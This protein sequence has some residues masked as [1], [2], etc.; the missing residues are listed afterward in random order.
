MPLSTPPA[1]R[2]GN[3]SAC[4]PITTGQGFGLWDPE[5]R[6]SYHD[7]H[8]APARRAPV[9]GHPLVDDVGHGAHR[10]CRRKGEQQAGVRAQGWGWAVHI[11]QAV[12]IQTPNG[13][14]LGVEIKTKGN[15]N[16]PERERE[17]A[18]KWLLR[19]EC[20]SRSIENRPRSNHTESITW[21]RAEVGVLR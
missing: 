14:E 15:G 18:W 7:L 10:L 16:R 11:L 5:G 12:C 2:I 17:T 9:H 19:N 20:I 4:C 13:Q 6:G 21:R 3:V 8:G 1:T